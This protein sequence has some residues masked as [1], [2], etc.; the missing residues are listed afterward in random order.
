[1]SVGIG[2]STELFRRHEI[3]QM[4]SYWNLVKREEGNGSVQ[5]QAESIFALRNVIHDEAYLSILS[6][7]ACSNHNGVPCRVYRNTERL[8]RL[9][10]ITDE[11]ADIAIPFELV[12]TKRRIPFIWKISKSD[13]FMGESIEFPD[14]HLPFAPALPATNH[15]PALDAEK[16]SETASQHA[17]ASESTGV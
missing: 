13:P 9:S 7:I 6:P 15:S 1:M 11:I 10:V 5:I 4:Q 8:F 2:I 17:R 14:E 16:T 12:T 3:R